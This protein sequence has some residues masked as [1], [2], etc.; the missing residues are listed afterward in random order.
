MKTTV[1]DFFIWYHGGE[2]WADDDSQ[3]TNTMSIDSVHAQHTPIKETHDFLLKFK[4]TKIDIKAKKFSNT[5][6]I[7][8]TLDAKKFL[9][10]STLE[11]PFNDKFLIISFKDAKKDDW[12]HRCV[13]NSMTHEII[14]KGRE[15]NDTIE[16]KL[17]MNGIEVKPTLLDELMNNIE[18][19]IDKIAKG[20]AKEKLEDAMREVDQLHDI[21]EEAC[22]TIREKYNLE[23][24]EW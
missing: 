9:I 4:Y 14:D 13:L 22:N 8:F 2:G 20:L 1:E 16:I 18:K 11:P 23:K 24:P 17:V 12:L 7:S 15:K 21:V 5:W 6:E 10:D 19:Y 3:I